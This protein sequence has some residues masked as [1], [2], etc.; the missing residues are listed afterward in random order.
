MFS[1]PFL[2]PV[3]FD[4]NAATQISFGYYLPSISYISFPH[5]FYS[6]VSF[7]SISCKNICL[8]LKIISD[9]LH[10]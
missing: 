4:I 1:N 9:N 5:T 10:F 2:L 7:K 8:D 3:H 6:L